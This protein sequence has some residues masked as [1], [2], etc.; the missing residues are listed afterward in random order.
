MP[1]VGRPGTSAWVSTARTPGMRERRAEVDAQDAGARVRAPQGGAPQH[2]VGVEVGGVGELAA[3]L[4]PAVLAQDALADAP[5]REGPGG[6][7]AASL[8]LADAAPRATSSASA[9]SRRPVLHHRGAAH[10]QVLHRPRRAQ[11]QRRHRVGDARLAGAVDPPEGDVRALSGLQR[12]DLVLAAEAAGRRGSSRAPAPCAPSSR[13]GRRAGAPPAAP[14]AARGRARRPRWTPRRPR[15]G[16]RRRRPPPGRRP[17]RCPSRGGR[18]RRGS[19]PP[20]CP[21]RRAA[22]P[23]CPDRCT[24]WASQTSGPSQSRRSRYSTGRTPKRSRQNRSSSIVSAR[25]VWSRTPRRRAR[26]ADSVIRPSVTE[27][28]EHGPTAIRS[29]APGAGSC[30]RSMAASVAA[31]DGVA[32]LDH[33]VRRQAALRGAEVHRAAA[34]VEAQPEPGG[35]ADRR[36]QQLAGGAREQVVVVGAGRAAR[37]RERGQGR[38][39]RVVDDLGVHARPARVERGEPAEEV[40]VL[41][42]PPCRPLVEVVVAVDQARAWPA[43]RGRRCAA[44]PRAAAAA[45]RSRRP[46]CAAPST[47]TQPSACSV[48]RALTVATAQPSM[49]SGPLSRAP[50]AA[51]TP[52]A[53]RRGSS[54]SRCSGRGCRRA[55]P[56]SPRRRAPGGGAAG[57]R[58]PRSGPG[59]Q[60]P[61]CTAPLSMKACCTTPTSCAGARPSTVTTARS[62][63]WRART[64][65]LQTSTSSSITEHEPHSPCSQ[66]FFAPAR[67]SRSRST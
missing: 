30:Q 58:R 20:R 36:L 10:Q 18:W 27:N 46:R 38:P 66:A 4:G 61:H 49:R 45:R 53:P 57:P 14:R 23:R 8:A 9:V 39:G 15:R 29:I 6:A 37:H 32:V 26:A 64:R 50:R 52:A 2:P 62:C 35:R 28:G 3:H 65:Q 51:P 13:P 16:P 43:G 48:P 11:D 5:E 42:Q 25:W 41:G 17:A 54:R 60:K 33:L 19:A 7:H 56:G 59:V 47:S 31:E 63:A 1:N 40:R 12:A 55:P 24:Q 67:P 22:R 44:R 34:G 21:W